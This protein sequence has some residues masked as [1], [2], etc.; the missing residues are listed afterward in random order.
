VL[1]EI[2]T[3]IQERV[4]VDPPPSKKLSRFRAS[5]KKALTDTMKLSA[6]KD[7]IKSLE[8]KLRDVM[9]RFGVRTPLYRRPAAADGLHLEITSLLQTGRNV[10]RVLERMSEFAAAQRAAKGEPIA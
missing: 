5:M 1:Q 4:P 9:D 6:D 10:E 8:R 2:Q 7:K 3:A